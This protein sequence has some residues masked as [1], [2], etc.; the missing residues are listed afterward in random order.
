MSRSLKWR[1]ILYA[2]IT[3][4]AIIVLMP[5]VTSQLPPWWSKIF[6]GDKIHKG[7]DL[8]G[9]MYLILEVQSDKAV[10]TYVERIKTS[11]ADDLKE[12][13]VPV[14]KL[15]REKT[16]QIVMEF[17]GSKDKVD[18]LLSQKYSNLQELSASEQ[19]GIWK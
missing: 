17:S 15:E 2:A 10:E 18:S 14:G 7:L 12:K 19:G 3:V 5:T 9:G 4:F 13:G 8:Q 1:F 6:P 16:D 11:L